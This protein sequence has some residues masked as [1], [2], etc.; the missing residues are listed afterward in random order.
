MPVPTKMA[1]IFVTASSNSPA[2]SESPTSADDYFRAIQSIVRHTEAKGSDIAS[3]ST[4]DLTTATGEFVD[5]T[6]TTTITAFGT[7]DSGIKRLLRFTGILTL[8]HNATSLQLPGS[9]NITT[10]V[11]DIAEFI[12]LGSG[13][14]KCTRYVKVDGTPVVNPT[15]A[16]NAII[17]RMLSDSANGSPMING[18]VVVSVAANAMTLAI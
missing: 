1:D 18:T 14:W 6:G 2:G 9:A 4:T 15:I 8:T 3:A 12:S 17:A 11:G 16:D 13:N 10:A 7:V 5:I